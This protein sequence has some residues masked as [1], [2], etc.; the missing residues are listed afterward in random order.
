[1]PSKK[2]SAVKEKLAKSGD[3]L[4][5]APVVEEFR[6]AEVM[7]VAEMKRN[8]AEINEVQHAP[9]MPKRWGAGRGKMTI[10]TPGTIVD[11]PTYIPEIVTTR[12]GVQRNVSRHRVI[13][14][15]LVVL[16]A[17]GQSKYRWCR[18]DGRK[19][20]L[21][22]RRGFTFEKYSATFEDTGLFTRGEGNTVRNGDIILMRIYLDGWEKMRA[23]KRRLQ[24]ILEG[25]TGGE[26]FAA[27]AQ[28]GVPTFKDNIKTGTREFYT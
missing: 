22:Q 8:V 1:M 26:L 15:Q 25:D 18:D 9:D 16:T 23:E 24:S 13:D 6:A 28:A 5:M 20:P 12:D 21:H 10:A 27:G 14:G 11:D 19:I 7:G 4:D 3:T 2:S 17:D